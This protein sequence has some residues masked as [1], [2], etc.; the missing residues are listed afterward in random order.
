MFIL[1]DPLETL[2]L[3]FKKIKK[4]GDFAS[5]YFNRDKSK[6]LCKIWYKKARINGTNWM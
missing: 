3:L 6:I 4:F 1:E 2:P 5:F